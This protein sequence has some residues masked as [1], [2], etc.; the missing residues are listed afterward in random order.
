MENEAQIIEST[1]TESVQDREARLQEATINF[2]DN[3]NTI[4]DQNGQLDN[5]VS[6]ALNELLT[7]AIGVEEAKGEE[8]KSTSPYS[9]IGHE[10]DKI[11][12]EGALSLLKG[13]RQDPYSFIKAINMLMKTPILHACD[14]REATVDKLMDEYGGALSPVLGEVHTL[15][16]NYLYHQANER[17]GNRITNTV[18][19]ANQLVDF[20]TQRKGDQIV[21]ENPLMIAN[22]AVLEMSAPLNQPNLTTPSKN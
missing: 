21:G 18:S 3:P 19:L 5:Q 8:R 13:E 2:F 17:F 20:A 11:F 16:K 6:S 22:E 12:Y 10:A 7:Q 14:E 15:S 1:K 9:N 4:L